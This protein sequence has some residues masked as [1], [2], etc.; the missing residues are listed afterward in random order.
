M[1]H[2]N[3]LHV[4][5]IINMEYGMAIPVDGLVIA[6]TQLSVDEAAMTGESDEMKKEILKVCLNRLQEK[7]AEGQK[8]GGELTRTHELPSPL[9]LSGT[10]IAGGE[11]RFMCLMVGEESCLG[12]IIAKLVVKPEVTPL[13]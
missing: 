10:N 2:H 1:V 9:I 11:G 8:E 7:Q 6:A 12:Q 4:G 5:D 13:Q 3:H